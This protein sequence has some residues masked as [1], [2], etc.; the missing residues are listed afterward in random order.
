[1]QR[2]AG[3]VIAIAGG[4]GGIGSAVSQRIASEG[5]KVVVG[6]VSLDSAREVAR[7]IVADGG[8]AIGLAI[9]IGDEASVSAFVEGAVKEFG[10]LDGFHVNALDARLSGTDADSTIID[11]QDYDDAMRVNLRGYFL[12]T[13]H[14][15]PQLVK[16]GGGAMLYTGS[17]AAYIG[18]P[19]KPVYA[20]GKAALG[21][22]ARQVATKWGGS[23]VR[24]NIVA[25]GLIV[26]ANSAAALGEE[27]LKT[28]ISEIPIARLGKPA[29][30]A[31]VAALLLSDDGS[32]VTGQVIGV[33]G[34]RMMRP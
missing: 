25:P 19:D 18:I 24:A 10:G 27:Y 30:I 12:C 22:L 8:T 28:A 20:M 2:F 31:A 33:D 14:A 34:G 9:D 13:R 32:Y 11:M 21:A 26:H 3:K 17:G 5:G 16:R 6:D 1:M 15:I 23:G 7:A 4:A 29:D